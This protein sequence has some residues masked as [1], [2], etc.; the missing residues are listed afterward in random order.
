MQ[1]VYEALD[2]AVLANELDKKLHESIVGLLR[3]QSHTESAVVACTEARNPKKVSLPPSFFV[4]AKLPLY[5]KR[6]DILHA[7]I[8]SRGPLSWQWLLPLRLTV[9]DLYHLGCEQL[10]LP[11]PDIASLQNG[12]VSVTELAVYFS[13]TK[14]DILRYTQHSVPVFCSCVQGE[15]ACR[16][17]DVTADWLLS[18]NATADNVIA[19]QISAEEAARTLKLD[20]THA[21]KFKFGPVHCK[22]TGWSY[23]DMRQ[24]FALTADDMAALRIDIQNMITFVR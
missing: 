16:L 10:A 21:L 8:K 13:K 18:I 4:T 24:A 12:A 6:S 23:S 19:L 7:L 11:V 14:E 9:H 2:R 17:L 3:A 15:E 22:I 20:R 1:A 5:C